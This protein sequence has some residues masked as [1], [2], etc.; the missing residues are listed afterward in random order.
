[1]IRLVLHYLPVT[2]DLVTS[3]DW[4]EQGQLLELEYLDLNLV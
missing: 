2:L 1:M 4:L 3:L